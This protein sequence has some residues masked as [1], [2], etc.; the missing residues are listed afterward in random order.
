MPNKINFKNRPTA[1]FSSLLSVVLKLLVHYGIALHEVR[2]VHRESCRLRL[3][4]SGY[5]SIIWRCSIANNSN[6]CATGQTETTILEDLYAIASQTSH[7]IPTASLQRRLECSPWPNKEDSQKKEL[8][9]S[10]LEVNTTGPWW[11]VGSL[12]HRPISHC[13]T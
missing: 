8:R 10:T 13:L 12:T 1:S 7:G 9:K 6:S 3:G 5:Y 4:R 11:T 2:S